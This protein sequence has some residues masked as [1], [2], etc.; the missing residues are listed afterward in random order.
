[1]KISPGKE[2]EKIEGSKLLSL[3]IALKSDSLGCYLPPKIQ[4][5]VIVY[6][7]QMFEE[8]ELPSLSPRS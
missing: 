8:V 5:T 7:E 2:N 6:L 3:Q 4:M 1:M